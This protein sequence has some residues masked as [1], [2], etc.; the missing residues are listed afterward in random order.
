M[1]QFF[2]NNKS[3][4]R[5]KKK[6]IETPK[7]AQ[8]KNEKKKGQMN[9]I[10]LNF[11]RWDHRFEKETVNF[12]LWTADCEWVRVCVLCKFLCGFCQKLHR[13]QVRC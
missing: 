12:V 10:D 5:R 3:S 1:V 9:R 4:E 6:E 13:T 7:L 2:T 8:T 11:G